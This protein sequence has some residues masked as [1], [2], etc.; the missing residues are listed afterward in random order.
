MIQANDFGYF[1]LANEKCAEGFIT[2]IDD[3][4]SQVVWL[5][6]YCNSSLC[7]KG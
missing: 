6:G 3:I 5:P 1:T 2:I 4:K 7:V